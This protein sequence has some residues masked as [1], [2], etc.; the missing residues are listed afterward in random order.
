MRLLNQESRAAGIHLVVG[1]SHPDRMKIH[2]DPGQ[3]ASL[4]SFEMRALLA[5]RAGRASDAA[6]EEDPLKRAH[7]AIQEATM[8]LEAPGHSMSVEQLREAQEPRRSSL[9][10]R[11]TRRRSTGR[12]TDNKPNPAALTRK[13]GFRG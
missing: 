1:R 12:P 11:D 10:P 5:D 6:L 8:L 4:S 9:D 2:A 3:V 7:E 13:R